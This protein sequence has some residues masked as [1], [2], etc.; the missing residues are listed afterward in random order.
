MTR[1]LSAED[2][3]AAVHDGAEVAF[4]DVREAG[5]FGEGHP[6]FAVPCPYSRLE[7]RAPVLVPRRDARTILID[8]GDGVAQRAAHRLTELGFGNVATVQGGCPAW[9]AAGFVLYKG[10][11]VPSKTL[12]EL[13]EHAFHPAMIDAATLAGWRAEG[14]P[15]RLYDARPPE[16]YAKMRV[17]GA[18]CLPNGEL[19]HRAPALP[20][21]DPL[22][23]T[24]A[25]RT[26]G[27]VGVLGL[28]EAGVG[29]EVYALENGTQ[30]WALA[31]FELERR[32]RAAAFPVLESEA[33]ALTRARADR[34]IAHH[35]IPV[36]DAREVTAWRDDPA[37]TTYLLDVRSAEEASADPAPAFDHALSGQLVQATDRWVGVRRARLVLLDDLGLRAALAAL[38]LKRLGYEPAV[39]RID[40]GLRR[41]APAP[42][43]SPPQ[44]LP[45]I[46]AAGAL[47]GLRSG[48]MRLLDLRPSRSFEADRAEGAE[49]TI[50][51]RLDRL[52]FE[53][54]R[55]VAIIDEDDGTAELAGKNLTERGI[56]ASKVAGG[57]AALL[58]AGARAVSGSLP[59]ADAIDH[60]RFVHDRHDG[61]LDASR[62]YLEWEQGLVAQLDTAERAEFLI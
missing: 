42:H 60:L 40:D 56:E 34:L 12:G 13:A 6:L 45:Q 58:A 7:L 27:I 17:P 21:A 54:E 3:R 33:A 46:S 51:P 47:A 15:V 11:N 16:E 1:I 14:R 32:N 2:A 22:V 37:R 52:G 36:L 55:A 44:A 38:W 57:Y 24:C 8:G 53:P 29:G 19:A 48:T 5:E 62:R 10:V 18:I 26:R 41:L 61:N 49:W 28:A 59:P 9:A 50:R 20:P 30:G 35:G 31:G 25:G 23:V 39:T 43:P 4:L